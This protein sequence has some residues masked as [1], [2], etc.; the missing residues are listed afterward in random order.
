MDPWFSL[1]QSPDLSTCGCASKGEPRSQ[2]KQVVMFSVQIGKA[3]VRLVSYNQL[4]QSNNLACLLLLEPKR[5]NSTFVITMCIYTQ[6]P[7]ASSGGRGGGGTVGA[8]I[9]G[10]GVSGRAGG[11]VSW[12]NPYHLGGGEGGR[13][14]H[15]IHGTI[16][17][18]IYM[19]KVGPGGGGEHIY[20]Y[21][22]IYQL[23]TTMCTIHQLRSLAH[24]VS[25]QNSK[26]PTSGA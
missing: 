17:I 2:R 9:R 15:G 13:Q 25:G 20:I 14:Q 24:V 5:K 12:G 18:Y 16:Y 23:L 10:L 26:A 22:C 11:G 21:I 6:R 8:R 19:G 7:G 1:R 3:S 4:F